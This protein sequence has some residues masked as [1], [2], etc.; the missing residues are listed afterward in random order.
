VG[1]LTDR[2]NHLIAWERLRQGT[3]GQ[4]AVTPREVLERALQHKASNIILVHNHPGGSARPSDPDL[5]LTAELARLAPALGMALL[6]HVVVT[7]NACYSL[8]RGAL[9]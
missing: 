9:L 6:D 1:A 7:E 2:G 5:R 8:D 3:V 4:V